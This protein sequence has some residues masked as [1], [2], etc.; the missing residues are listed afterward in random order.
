MV[1]DWRVG[2]EV[3]GREDVGEEKPGAES[4]VDLH[5]RFAIPAESGIAGE[6][7]FEDRAGIDIEFLRA[8]ERLQ[9]LIKLLEFFFDQIVV[10]VVPCVAG[11]A[12]AAGVVFGE[13]VVSWEII[14]READHRAAAGQYLARVAA[15]MRVALEPGH[16]A[17]FAVL[18][19]IEKF[20]RMACGAGFGEAT[21][22]EAGLGGPMFHLCLGRGHA[23]LVK[24]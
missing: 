14:E 5:R 2:R 22:V 19:P 23:R 18:D 11:D 8:A 7:A 1:A 24:K 12:V 20:L 17:V 15:A 6:I 4:A 10:I 3:E 16:F 21:I 13:G 9:F